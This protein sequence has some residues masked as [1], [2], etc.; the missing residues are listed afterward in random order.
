M[1]WS[2]DFAPASP[3]LPSA[4]MH[5]TLISKSAEPTP[6]AS[7]GAAFAAL[8]P[9]A[10]RAA[11]AAQAGLRSEADTFLVT[12]AMAIIK[13]AV[14][15]SVSVSS[16]ARLSISG[17]ALMPTAPRAAAA[18]TRTP[19]S[20]LPSSLPISG[21]CDAAFS[22]RPE[23]IC[24]ALMRT[25]TS[26]SPRSLLAVARYFSALAFGIAPR[27]AAFTRGWLLSSMPPSASI[28]AS[29]E[30][31][32]MQALIT[33]STS[34]SFSLAAT[35]ADAETAFMLPKAMHASTTMSRSLSSRHS[36]TPSAYAEAA[37]PRYP[38]A[39]IDAFLTSASRAIFSLSAMESA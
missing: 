6:S 34:F 30:P 3:I 12:P 25:K 15:S 2:S 20:L 27:A 9:I 7:A 23:I 10:P 38:R 18:A 24:M 33:T 19:T 11:A 37:S 5:A 28:S 36:S 13:D 8:L 17:S 31:R 29:M 32:P 1:S 26:P 14:S 39:W 4:V 35:F 16:F 22:P 21:T